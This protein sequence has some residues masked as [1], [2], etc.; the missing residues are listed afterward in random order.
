[1]NGI[2]TIRLDVHTRYDS[3]SNR[4]RIPP[5]EGL[6]SA[7]DADKKKQFKT[8]I[9]NEF[10]S[11]KNQSNN[12]PEIIFSD[13]KYYRT[14]LLSEIYNKMSGLENRTNP[15]HFVEYYA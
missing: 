5:L 13:S 14:N 8:E 7:T 12:H 10:N 15:G 1:L 2:N 6:K 9:S 4:R 11:R 3:A